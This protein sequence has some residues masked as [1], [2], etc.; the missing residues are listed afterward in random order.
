MSTVDD[1][2][3]VATRRVLAMGCHATVSVLA[4]DQ[5]QA[6]RSV[7]RA[8]RRLRHLER[9]WTRF[10]DTSD[11]SAINRADGRAVVVDSTT[12]E[13]IR[14]MIVAHR[15]TQGACDAGYLS[16]SGISIGDADLIGIDLDRHVVRFPAGTRLDPGSL[17][18][19]LAADLIA[20]QSIESG[21]LGAL[22]E[23]GG[24]VRVAGV[25]PHHGFWSIAVE[26]PF[27]DVGR[28]GAV[29]VREAG[30]ATSGLGMSRE[31]RGP[32]NVSVDPRTGEPLRPTSDRV[33]SATVITGSA[34]EAEM[35]STALLVRDDANFEPV[36]RRAGLAR[37]VRG[38]GSIRSTEEWNR[39]FLPASDPTEVVHV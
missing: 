7:D 16:D 21:A 39:T 20:S 31:A 15:V 37:I 4:G 36:I 27:G 9:C 13:L 38:D 1:V 22:V 33:V 28:Q 17:G 34:V 5:C 8:V 30:V 26:D 18:K 12:V 29:L 35:W 25:G 6:E 10:D 3:V 19:G 23:I 2:G 11:V 24:D 32:V 14:S